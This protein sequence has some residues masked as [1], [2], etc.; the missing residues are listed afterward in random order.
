MTLLCNAM[1]WEVMWMDN[2]KTIVC[3]VDSHFCELSE[4][5]ICASEYGCECPYRMPDDDL[6]SRL[7][8]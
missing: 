6:G 2:E 3:S 7:E 1:S 4:G 8:D 5:G